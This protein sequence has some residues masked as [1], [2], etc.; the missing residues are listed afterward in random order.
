[1]AIVVTGFGPFGEHSTNASWEGVRLV[2][3]LWGRRQPPVRVEQIPV[4]YSWVQGEEEARWRE[5]IFTV[6]VGVSSRDSVVTLESQAH[7]TGYCT[8]DT[9][10]RCPEGGCCVTGGPEVAG[11]CLDMARLLELVRGQAGAQS[12]LQF[13]QSEDPG[14]FLCDF[15]YYRS[16]HSSGGRSLF[17]HVP[18][19]GKPYSKEQLGEALVAILGAVVRMVGE[20]EE[21]RV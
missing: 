21:Q 5:A 7:N 9:Q 17:V 14:R 6:H 20:Q 2:P 3:E 10:A 11:T 8:P 12:G 13:Q 19:L 16:L 18:P 1:M 4:Q 15:V